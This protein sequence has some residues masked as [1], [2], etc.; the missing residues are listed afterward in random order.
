MVAFTVAVGAGLGD[1]V[2]VLMA[3]E[4]TS[5]SGIILESGGDASS[6]GSIV[7]ISV[8]VVEVV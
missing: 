6:V 2:V 8:L 5:V 1:G 3:S 7:A 4:V